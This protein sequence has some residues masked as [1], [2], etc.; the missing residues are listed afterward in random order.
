MNAVADLAGTR[1][2]YHD[3]MNSTQNGSIER[4]LV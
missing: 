2:M 1:Y 4:V 3:P